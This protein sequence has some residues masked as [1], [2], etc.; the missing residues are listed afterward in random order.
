MPTVMTHNDGPKLCP[1]CNDTCML[2][3]LHDSFLL[4]LLVLT[5]G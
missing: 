5:A 2:L 4:I 3:H 1:G